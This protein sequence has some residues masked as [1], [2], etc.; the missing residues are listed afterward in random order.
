MKNRKK[1][2]MEGAR[3]RTCDRRGAG[4]L[5]GARWRVIASTYLKGL[6]ILKF[7]RGKKINESTTTNIDFRETEK[8]S[9][10]FATAATVVAAAALVTPLQGHVV[11]LILAAWTSCVVDSEC[12]V[13]EK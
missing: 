10:L 1:L 5:V 12:R 3:A 11:Y 4:G 7:S 9:T 13:P 8:V 6:F 2:M